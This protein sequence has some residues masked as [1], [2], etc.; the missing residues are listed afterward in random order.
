MTRPEL[1]R[2]RAAIA[3]YPDSVEDVGDAAAISVLLAA[4]RAALAAAVT[5][6]HGV[7]IDSATLDLLV[8]RAVGDPHLAEEVQRAVQRLEAHVHDAHYHPERVATNQANK[9]LAAFRAL[10][11]RA[12]ARL[13]R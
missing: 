5:V 11:N 4:I 6:G 3:G 7:P 12:I 9:D 10:M 13:R 1:V 2:L 8:E